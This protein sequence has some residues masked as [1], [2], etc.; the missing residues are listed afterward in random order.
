VVL[1]SGSGF[2]VG[3]GVGI[4]RVANELVKEK[5]LVSRVL[6]NVVQLLL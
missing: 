5:L 6:S 1:E 4:R 3:V 2:G